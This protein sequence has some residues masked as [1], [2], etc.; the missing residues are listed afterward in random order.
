[1]KK[2]RVI[3]C[4]PENTDFRQAYNIN[5]NAALAFENGLVAWKKVQN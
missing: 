3:L 2:C 1:M 4:I 5:A